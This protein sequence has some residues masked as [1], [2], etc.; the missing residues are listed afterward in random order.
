MIQLKRVYEKPSRNDGQQIH[1]Q[2]MNIA[3]PLNRSEQLCAALFPRHP[4]PRHALHL[5]SGVYRNRIEIMTEVQR[6]P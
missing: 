6:S 4:T 2:W 1:P 5:Y 3:S